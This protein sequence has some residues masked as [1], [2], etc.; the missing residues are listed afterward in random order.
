MRLGVLALMLALPVSAAAQSLAL[1]VPDPIAS[2]LADVR[3]AHQIERR[4]SGIVLI[5]AGLASVIGGAITA[6]VGHDDP[7]W[8]TFGLGTAGWGAVNAGLAI[9]MLDLGDGGLAAIERD[10]ALRYDELARARERAL[11]AQHDTATIYALNLGLDVFYV[12]AGVLSFFLA[13]LIDSAH[14]RDLLRGYSVAM[15][16]QGVFLFGFDLV[17]WITSSA[18][19]DRIAAIEIPR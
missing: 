12:A 7:F 8:L 13:D 5:T 18:R 3:R 6:G 15:L 14:D 19:A 10:R 1:T 11:R 2:E 16:G 9:A 17:G 4:E